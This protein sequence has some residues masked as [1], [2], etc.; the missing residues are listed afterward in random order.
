LDVRIHALSAVIAS[1]EAK[2]PLSLE[3]IKL[4]GRLNTTLADLIHA[5]L[6]I[7]RT[8][9]ALVDAETLH[10][11]VLALFDRLITDE[12]L[13]AVVAE[14]FGQLLDELVPNQHTN[15]ALRQEAFPNAAQL[16]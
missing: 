9:H 14:A 4:L 2:A 10:P 3:E 8:S 15:P 7:E 12:S 5:R 11:H 1:L 13:R 6:R 16:R